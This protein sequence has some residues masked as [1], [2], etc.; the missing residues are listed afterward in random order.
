MMFL[1]PVT[2][3]SGHKELLNVSVWLAQ[4]LI[5]VSLCVSGVVKLLM[6]VPRIAKVFSWTGQVSKSF[7]RF[8]GV[9][10]LAGGV[11]IILPTLTHIHPQLSD[12]AALSCMLLQ[13]LAIRFHAQSKEITDTPFN[14]FVLFL[15]A[16]VLWGRW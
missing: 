6:P 2:T 13:V 9:G 14:F 1:A 3:D 15:S 5:S 16:F 7:L 11:G 10:D 8:I 4:G 12:V